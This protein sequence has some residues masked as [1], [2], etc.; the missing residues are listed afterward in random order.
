M[1]RLTPSNQDCSNINVFGFAF[2][3]T[4]SLTIS[5]VNFF[6]LRFFV[7]LQRFRKSLAPRLDL[8]VNDDVYQLQRRAFEGNEDAVWIGL[9]KEIPVTSEKFL[10][11]EVPTITKS[12]ISTP[13]P[14]TTVELKPASTIRDPLSDQLRVNETGEHISSEANEHPD[15]ANETRSLSSRTAANSSVHS[16][17]EAEVI[18]RE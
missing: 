10:L 4:V 17:H 9:T 6:I 8:W 1:E 13:R 11:S 3:I 16:V 18:R 2:T 14:D 7:F 12:T 5:I 15:I